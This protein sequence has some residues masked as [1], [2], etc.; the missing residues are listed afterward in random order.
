MH[1]FQPICIRLAFVIPHPP[2]GVEVYSRG[3]GQP[4]AKG[5]D[6][7]GAQH[8]TKLS[9]LRI[10]ILETISFI[11]VVTH[12]KSRTRIFCTTAIRAC[13]FFEPAGTHHCWVW[14][15]SHVLLCICWRA[16][17]AERT[18]RGAVP[19]SSQPGICIN[20]PCRLFSYGYCLGDC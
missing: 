16:F 19:F 3:H 13:I 17:R 8:C 9:F 7:E 18:R 10:T 11:F 2:E 4:K 1:G 6:E 14:C 20:K 5:K 15:Q 12:E